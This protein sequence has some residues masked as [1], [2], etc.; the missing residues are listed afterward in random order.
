LICDLV[1]AH[2]SDDIDLVKHPKYFFFDI[3]VVNGVLENYKASEERNGLLMEH[4]FFNQLKNHSYCF[5]KK[6]DIS[7]F[8]ARN[9]LE[10]DFVIEIDGRT[11]L[12]EVKSSSPSESELSPLINV[13]RYFSAA[14]ECFVACAKSEARKIRGIRI[15]GW[16]EVI[17]EIFGK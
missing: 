3:G 4:L 2:Q 16:Q 11:I 15:L 13:R 6:I 14:T 9:G 17:K 12:V 8:R 1:E 10:V 7:H 5:D